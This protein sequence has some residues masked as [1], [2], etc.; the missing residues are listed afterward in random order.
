M[1]AEGVSIEDLADRWYPSLREAA[2]S[3]DF[4][5]LIEMLRS[6]TPMDA[7]DRRRLAD[8]L[9]GALRSQL[10][11][12]DR[13]MRHHAMHDVVRATRWE[14]TSFAKGR[15]PRDAAEWEELWGYL[16]AAGWRDVPP[17]TKGQITEAAKLLTCWTWR[18]TRDQLDEL[19]R[20][21][22]RAERK[23]GKSAA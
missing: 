4:G 18:L 6:D 11:R 2:L 8:L 14:L 3:G 12:Q 19:L 9:A 7:H 20:K 15:R 5:P 13:R 23:P 17:S 22:P 16:Q 10:R 21:R 1:P